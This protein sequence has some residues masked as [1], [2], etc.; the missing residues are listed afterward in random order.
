V[1][2]IIIVW[3]RDDEKLVQVEKKSKEKRIFILWN[4]FFSKIGIKNEQI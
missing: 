3:G 2:I 1:E 4:S